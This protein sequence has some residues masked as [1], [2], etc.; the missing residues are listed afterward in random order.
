M[1]RTSRIHPPSRELFPPRIRSPRIFASG[2]AIPR[3]LSRPNHFLSPGAPP[4][5][6]D[7]QDNSP[8]MDLNAPSIPSVSQPRL[9][10][11]CR[12]EKV[13]SALSLVC[14]IPFG[15]DAPRSPISKRRRPILP[16]FVPTLHQLVRPCSML[17]CQ[18]PDLSKKERTHTFFFFPLG[19]A[20][21]LDQ[22]FSPQR[23]SGTVLRRFNLA[24]SENR[25]PIR[26]TRA[27][28]NAKSFFLAP[29]LSI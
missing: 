1:R 20:Y 25:H 24:N 7:H 23:S 4:T 12:L 22:T 5:L 16:V 18:E 6:P 17:S 10:S 15:R 13:S 3:P 14:I 9:F 29:Y 2:V 28:L 27:G 11:I 19:V 21:G 26:S 8:C